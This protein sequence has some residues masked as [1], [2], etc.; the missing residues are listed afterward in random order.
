[1]TLHYS[2][3][4]YSTLHYSTLHYIHEQDLVHTIVCHQRGTSAK[5][6]EPT[7]L[8]YITVQYITSH[9]S[10]LHYSKVKYIALHYSTLH[11]V[12]LHYIA[13]HHIALHAYVH[14]KQTYIQTYIHTR[15]DIR[16]D[17]HIQ[18]IYTD[19]THINIQYKNIY[20]YKICLQSNDSPPI[21]PPPSSRPVRRCPGHRLL[22]SDK[23]HSSPSHSSLQVHQH[24]KIR[25]KSWEIMGYPLI[26]GGLI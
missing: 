6:S 25:G 4:Q 13:L 14:Y 11:Y 22:G 2:T 15:T 24:L 18:F 3:L 20:T 9:Y 1:M 26:N 5:S 10:R 12:A 16:T 19:I 7:Y 23:S 17:I 8:H 21:W